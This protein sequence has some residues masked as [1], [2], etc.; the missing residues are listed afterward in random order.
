MGKQEKS[1]EKRAGSRGG[2]VDLPMHCARDREKRG[3]PWVWGRVG[4]FDPGFGLGLYSGSGPGQIWVELGAV[5]G[6]VESLEHLGGAVERGQSLRGAQKNRKQAN[7]QWL[8]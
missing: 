7:G 4:G 3:L 5:E 1:W 2:H 8:G 6:A